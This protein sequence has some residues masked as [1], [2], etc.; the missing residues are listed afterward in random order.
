M[1]DVSVARAEVVVDLPREAAVLGL[2]G[3]VAARSDRDVAVVAAM[4]GAEILPEVAQDVDD[5]VAAI[6]GRAA[7]RPA[8]AAVVGSLRLPMFEL[9]LSST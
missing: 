4:Q 2:A 8:A 9:T 1:I 3:I 5:V 7:L 6:V